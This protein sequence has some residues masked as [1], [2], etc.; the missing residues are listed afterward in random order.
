M[1]VR[2]YKNNGKI[3]TKLIKRLKEKI[4]KIERALKE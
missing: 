2:N 1:G 3:A 4:Q